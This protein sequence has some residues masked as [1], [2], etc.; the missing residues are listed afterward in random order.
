MSYI[1]GFSAIPAFPVNC[2]Q[3]RQNWYLPKLHDFWLFG[4]AEMFAGIAGIA[5]NSQILDNTFRCW[6]SSQRDLWI[7]SWQC[8][9]MNVTNLWFPSGTKLCH[10]FSKCWQQGITR[11]YTWCPLMR[12]TLHTLGGQFKLSIITEHVSV[13]YDIVDPAIFPLINGLLWG[14]EYWDPMLFTPS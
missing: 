11:V 8:Y 5:E 12:P 10:L 14:S 4:I 6:S 3:F 2:L 7:S 13:H 1:S 9:V